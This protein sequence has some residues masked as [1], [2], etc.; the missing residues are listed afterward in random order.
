MQTT[1]NGSSE[2]IDVATLRNAVPWWPYSTHGTYRLIRARKLGAVAVGRRRFVTR[3]LL[4]AF[5]AKHTVAA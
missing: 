2:L 1:A 4:S 5:I 3:D